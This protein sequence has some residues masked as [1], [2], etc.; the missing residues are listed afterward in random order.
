MQDYKM[1]CTLM[2]YMYVISCHNQTA[3]FAISRGVIELQTSYRD[4]LTFTIESTSTLFNIIF[5]DS[6]FYRWSKVRSRVSTKWY[7]EGLEYLEVILCATIPA[8]LT[9]TQP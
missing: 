8:R 2:S 1:H 5:T 4:K 9:V 7:R 6:W 3:A